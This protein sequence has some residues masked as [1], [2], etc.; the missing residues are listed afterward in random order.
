MKV[1]VS[2]TITSSYHVGLR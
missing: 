1:Y 2:Y